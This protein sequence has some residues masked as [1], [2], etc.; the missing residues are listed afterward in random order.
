[1]SLCAS[2]LSIKHGQT[3]PL[4]MVIGFLLPH[5]LSVRAQDKKLKMNMIDKP[6]NFGVITF[7]FFVLKDFIRV[8]RYFVKKNQS[9]TV[10]IQPK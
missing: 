3:P 4:C 10:K 9:G 5:F 1:M 8:L 6:P 2:N 7:S